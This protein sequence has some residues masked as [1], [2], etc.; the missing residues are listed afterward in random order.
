MFY[1]FK[2]SITSML[3]FC[4]EVCVFDSS[5]K[6]DGTLAALFEMQKQFDG[7]L[8]IKHEDIDWSAPNHGIFDGITKQKARQ[9]C[10]SE[11][12]F[13]FDVD[14]IMHEHYSEMIR[15]FIEQISEELRKVPIIA[16]PVVEYWG[17]AGKV[18]IDV[19]P[20]KA[21]ISL[22]VRDIVH[23]IPAHLRIV[24]EKTGLEYA[25]HG[26]DTCDYISRATGEPYQILSFFPQEIEQTRMVAIKSNPFGPDI[27]NFELWFNSA[28]KQM[29]S[30]F[31]Y[32]WFNIERKIKQ[33]RMFW[34]T[35]WKAMYN[36]ERDER[37]NPFFPGSLWSE[38][39]DEMIKQKALD[40]EMSTSGHVFHKKWEGDRTN[41]IRV[42]K[43]HP[44]I[45]KDWIEKYSK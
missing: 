4:D 9:M 35:F 45:M 2:E 43:D 10:R 8:K 36:E 12:L 37:Q 28:I 21:R 1:P 42:F 18:R 22:N 14:E 3:S 25:K 34:T 7:K 23:G 26:T 5:D 20:W 39:T 33:Y 19:N 40:L 15:P 24:D 41:S 32:S 11:Y 38:V 13:Q 29:P 16:L 30:I 31:H 6:D 27:K 44:A 17:R